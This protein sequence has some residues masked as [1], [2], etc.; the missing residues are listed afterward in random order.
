MERKEMNSWNGSVTTKLPGILTRTINGKSL[1]AIPNIVRIYFK[2]HFE[3]AY[4]LC[5]TDP[6]L[7]KNKQNPT[8]FL[9]NMG[10]L[11]ETGIFPS[12]K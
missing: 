6:A 4:L 10:L 11:A 1:R 9:S 2:F 5:S 8:A 12:R 7:W 3:T